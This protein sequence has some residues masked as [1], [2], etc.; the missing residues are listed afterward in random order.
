[1]ITDILAAKIFDAVIRPEKTVF[2]SQTDSRNLKS[3]YVVGDIKEY[4]V[5]CLDSIGQNTVHAI[6]VGEDTTNLPTANSTYAMGYIYIRTSQ[7]WIELTERT[8]N[9]I[10]RCNYEDGVWS[11]WEAIVPVD[12]ELSETSTNTI[13]NKV[14]TNKLLEVET[15][16]NTAIGENRNDIVDL[17]GRV[18]ELE[19][20]EVDTELSA[21][22]EN[23]VQNKVVTEALDGKLNKFAPN[24][25]PTNN[26]IF[27]YG[28]Y[29]DG[30]DGAVQMS[31]YN[32]AL[33]W[34]VPM[35]SSGGALRIPNYEEGKG[36]N[37]S[38]FPE[39]E[40]AVNK[41]YVDGKFNGANKAV[42]FADYSS[43]ILSLNELSNTVYTVSQNI[44]IVTRKVPDLWVSAI[45]DRRVSYTYVSDDDFVNELD[46]N[47][48]VQVGYYVLSPLETQKVDLTEYIKKDSVDSE[49]DYSSTNAI[50][51][52]PVAIAIDQHKQQL[53]SLADRATK[54]ENKEVDITVDTVL[55]T[56]SENPVQNKI[57]TKRIEEVAS[58]AD[59]A[60]GK[61]DDSHRRLD[62]LEPRVTELENQ[63][64]SGGNVTID[65]ELSLESENAVQNK[66]VTEA[67]DG[68]LDKKAWTGSANTYKIYGIKY[69]GSQILLDATH[70]NHATRYTIPMRNVE[71]NIRIPDYVEGQPTDAIPAGQIAVNK[72][73]VDNLFASVG[74]GSGGSGTKWYNHRIA[75]KLTHDA[76]GT[77]DCSFNIIST[78]NVALTEWANLPNAS[79]VDMAIPLIAGEGEWQWLVS[80]YEGFMIGTGYYQYNS[81]HTALMI[82][83]KWWHGFPMGVTEFKY[84]GYG[85]T[86]NGIAVSNAEFVSDTV[87][88]L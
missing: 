55:S 83:G 42:S 23:V 32:M 67:L 72:N 41:N 2:V 10:Y 51:N 35:R 60:D 22:S 11:N 30:T 65:S 34:T 69:D 74:G 18:T 79:V 29:S 56:E 38:A 5:N 49:L 58:I 57:V 46:T 61:S 84:D 37:G 87:I 1:M 48:I 54:L 78:S 4:A 25:I 7:I 70:Y 15:T 47:G 50:Q 68:K 33:P 52:R 39:G 14:I 12:A 73:Y 88:S 17:K 86:V 66:V 24:K 53:E 40:L 8:T 3:T 43:M 36:T 19:N 26:G 81:T 21:E 9:A 77:F 6:T 27:L 71:G 16:A 63:G 31:N 85:G 59:R 75:F 44:M 76:V 45:V 28:R 82:G 80:E 13:Q 64:G 20:K 62:D